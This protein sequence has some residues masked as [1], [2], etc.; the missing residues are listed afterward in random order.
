MKTLEN[1]TKNFTIAMLILIP[2]FIIAV[3]PYCNAYHEDQI[4]MAVYKEWQCR[5]CGSFNPKANWYCGSCGAE[6]P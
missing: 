3:W 1:D 2:M 4:E 5:K 6:R